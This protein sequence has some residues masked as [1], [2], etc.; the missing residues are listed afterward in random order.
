MAI[1]TTTA[2]AIAA[3]ATTAATT[4]NS[5]VQAGKQ[6]KLQEKAENEAEKAMADAKKR[7]G[8]NYAEGLSIQKEPYE[9]E[10]EAL[11]SAGAQA[12]QAGVEGDVRGAGATAGRVQA[13]QQAG[14]RQIATAMGQDM[15]GLEKAAAAED[16]RIAQDLAGLDMMELSGAQLAARDAEKA[17]NAAIQQGV[18]GV[19]SF[20]QQ[21]LQ[22]AP[23]YSKTGGN[24]KGSP[25][26]LN[27][28]VDLESLAQY[29]GGVT[30]KLGTF[31][32]G[33]YDPQMLDQFRLGQP[34]GGA[35]MSEIELAQ[36]RAN[37]PS[38][39]TF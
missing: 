18:Q 38:Q 27:K 37:N 28:A 3:L 35:M 7:L 36:F 24:D 4:T 31:S 19:Q 15:L 29:R 32:E 17:R 20:V 12:I 30:P 8:V 34:F 13:A 25:E 1:A 9:L 33:F 6:K 10:R 22:F 16:A 14:Q 2:L 39:I 26:Q 21:G 23:L 11:I 5:F